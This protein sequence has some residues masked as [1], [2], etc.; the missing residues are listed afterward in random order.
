MRGRGRRL[1]PGKPRAEGRREWRRQ[2]RARSCIG[3]YALG[4]LAR[5]GPVGDSSAIVA[6]VGV[7]EFI[8]QGDRLLA[9]SSGELAAVDGD[10]SGGVGKKL[11]RAVV[12]C[13]RGRLSAPGMCASAYDAS[14]KTSTIVREESC[15]RRRSSSREISG[16]LDELVAA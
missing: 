14:G 11:A 4:R 15:S 9:A 1:H 6:N 8:E 2:V 7:A 10:L 16:M 5:L 13:S 12:T 3:A